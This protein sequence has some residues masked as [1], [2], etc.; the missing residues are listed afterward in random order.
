MKVRVT[1][2]IFE[3]AILKNDIFCD[4][5][6]VVDYIIDFI[7]PQLFFPEDPIIKMGTAGKLIYFLANGDC[8]VSVQNSMKQIK[9]VNELHQGDYFG[10]ISII[11]GAVRSANVESINYCT[12]AHLS[13]EYFHKMCNLSPEIFNSLKKRALEDYDDDWI[14]FKCTL[15]DQ[16]HYFQNVVAED[17]Q[18]NFY[19]EI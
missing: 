10:E 4:K 17:E 12:L 7:Q 3:K 1:N 18:M 8:Q 15:L 2:Y 16:I 14:R 19:K 5:M 11:F 6:E 13:S 9:L